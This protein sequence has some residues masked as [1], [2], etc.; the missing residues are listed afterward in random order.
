MSFPYIHFL[1]KLYVCFEGLPNTPTCLSIKFCAAPSGV[2]GGRRVK[3]GMLSGKINS[4][5]C[6]EITVSI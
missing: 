2:G 3:Q 4:L 5:L 1:F 6:F